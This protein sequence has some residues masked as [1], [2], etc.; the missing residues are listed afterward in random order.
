VLC[1]FFLILVDKQTRIVF[2]N[3]RLALSFFVFLLLIFP[4]L[5]WNYENNWL[6]FN[7]T[8]DNISLNSIGFNFIGLVEFVSSQILM[9]GPILFFSFLFFYK[10]KKLG[11]VEKFLLCFSLPVIVIVI[12]ESLLVRAH[13]NWAAV[14]FVSLSVFFIESVY[15][16]NKKIIFF[17]NYINL[18]LGLVLFLMIAAS[19]PLSFFDRIRGV[20]SL[21][22]FLEDK[23]KSSIKNMVISDRL[24]YASISYEY[25]NKEIE[26]YSPFKPGAKVAHHFQLKNALP[27]NFSKNFIL[28]GYLNDVD[29][30]QKEKGVKLIG[31]KLF[32]F[33]KEK[34][35]IYEIS[36]K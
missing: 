23:N 10:K 27:K 32:P 12:V 33:T 35:K 36:F 16:A 20:Q 22:V 13:G 5:F 15:R 26:M 30:L 19:Y 24:V 2:L 21:I 9:V 17:N 18:L 25:R 7:H 1:L 28:I 31:S 4:N 11:F 29:Y 8:A 14:S 3:L 6:T 34:I